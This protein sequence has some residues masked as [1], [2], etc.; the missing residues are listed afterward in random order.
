MTGPVCEVMFMPWADIKVETTIGPFRIWEWDKS[1]VTDNAIAEHLDQYFKSQV[2]HYGNP[3][4]SVTIVTTDDEFAPI[5]SSLLDKARIAADMLLFS[6]V[7]PDLKAR[8]AAKRICARMPPT[9]DRFQLIKQTFTPG[10]TSIAVH[11]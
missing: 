4:S 1:R 8:I 7:Y 3:V 11:N 10:D 5:S 6:M 2:D 9:A